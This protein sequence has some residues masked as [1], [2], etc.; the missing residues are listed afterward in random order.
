MIDSKKHISS[1]ILASQ[2][3]TEQETST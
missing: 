2:L 1:I 3:N